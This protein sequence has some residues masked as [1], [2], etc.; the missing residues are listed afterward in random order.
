MSLL[1]T[2]N[3]FH[4][5]FKCFSN[6]FWTG[7]CLLH[8]ELLNITC[9]QRLLWI[10]QISYQKYF[11]DVMKLTN[12]AAPYT[13][14][15]QFFL[16]HFVKLKPLITE[17]RLAK[18]LRRDWISLFSES[19]TLQIQTFSFMFAWISGASDFQNACMRNILWRIL[20]V[21][22]LIIIE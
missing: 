11:V 14:C 22:I 21:Y 12:G 8:H 19:P 20:N 2:L 7:K 13:L 17:E 5:F 1:L 15:S 3:I 6:W 9:F 4:I 18:L 16:F 10:L